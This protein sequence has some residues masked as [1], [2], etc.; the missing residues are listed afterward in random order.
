M[1]GI[2]GNIKI[3]ETKPERVLYLLACIRSYAFLKDVCGFYLNLEN[4]SSELFHLVTTE[5]KKCGFKYVLTTGIFN[6]YGEAYC[7]LLRG[8]KDKLTEVNGI[9]QPGL[10]FNFM[11]DQFLLMNSV[12]EVAEIE[13]TMLR[14]KIDVCMCGF[15]AVEKNSAQGLTHYSVTPAGIVYTNQ[16]ECYTE[17]CKFYGARYYLGVNFITTI[18]FAIK[19]WSRD[20]G[21]RPHEYEISFYDAN[22]LHNVLIPKK[23]IQVAIDDDH[24]ADNSCLLKRKEEK[25]EKII[26]E[27]KSEYQI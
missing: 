11:E 5:L 26:R 13:N 9:P 18:S 7:F 6:N 19:F 1:T 20:C 4:P 14:Y 15:N 17:F 8:I 3:D 22:F 24:G 23:E 16:I 27:I 2:V 25:W 21:P 12:E 10:I